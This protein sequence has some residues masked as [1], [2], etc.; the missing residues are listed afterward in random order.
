ML[1]PGVYAPNPHIAFAWLWINGTPV[2]VDDF[3]SRPRHLESFSCTFEVETLG[4]F[5]FVLFD[6]EYDFIEELV[7]KSEGKCTFQFGYTT[8]GLKSPVYSGTIMEYTPE[9]LYDGIRI[10]LRGFFTALTLHKFTKTRA[11]TGK[12]VSDIVREIAVNNGFT[13]IVDDTKKVEYH[14]DLQTTDQKDKTFQQHN[15]DWSFMVNT[16]QKQAVRE[17]DDVGGYIMYVDEEKKELHFHPPKMEEGPVKTFVWRDKMTE[18]IEFSPCYEG[19]LLARL[20]AGGSTQAAAR[21]A[22]TGVTTDN[23]V[24]DKSL[25][26]GKGAATDPQRVQGENPASKTAGQ[27]TARIVK[28]FH[29]SA[30]AENEAKFWWW[31][32]AWKSALTG[33]LVIVGDPRVMPYKKYEIQVAKKSGGL[34]WT[35]GLYYSHGIHH[36]IRGGGYTST[37]ELWRTGGKTGETSEASRT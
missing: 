34:H 28:D 15:T 37:L 13:P 30:M 14:E 25:T 29:D 17:K 11:W 10:H 7:T 21:D 2:T 24:H 32:E 16:L 3:A 20:L 33:Q 26:V 8:G 19:G 27:P 18:V 36:E 9:F 12:R 23:L 22:V 1:E 4:D 6:P 5:E 35:S 31:R